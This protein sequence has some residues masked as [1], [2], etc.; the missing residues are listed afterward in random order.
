MRLHFCSTNFIIQMNSVCIGDLS[1]F[2]ERE[3]QNLIAKIA[4]LQEEVLKYKPNIFCLRESVVLIYS[5]VTYMCLL[6]QVGCF[7]SGISSCHN[8]P[9]MTPQNFKVAVEMDQLQRRITELCEV[10]TDLQV[11]LVS[12]IFSSTLLHSFTASL[13]SV[14][15]FYSS[16][17]AFLLH[18]RLPSSK[19]YLAIVNKFLAQKYATALLLRY[20]YRVTVLSLSTGT[21]SHLRYCCY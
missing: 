15:S 17:L 21:D 6:L 19:C 20:C 14:F 7:I 13:C 11:S 4:S 16:F 12:S 1:S 8:L 10:N 9:L 5:S 3:N 18:M 2:Q